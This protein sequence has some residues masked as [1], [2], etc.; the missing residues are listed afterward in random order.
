MVNQDFLKLEPG[1]A[2]V[3]GFTAAKEVPTATTTYT[4]TASNSLGEATATVTV[5][6]GP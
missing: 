2:N 4:L 3:T 1:N 6:V 5:N